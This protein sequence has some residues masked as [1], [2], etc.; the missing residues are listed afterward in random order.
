MP[1]FD[2]LTACT[3]PNCDG[4]SGLAGR[5]GA[6]ADGPS[7]SA[8]RRVA[9]RPPRALEL[10]ALRIEHDHPMI[11]VAVGDEQ[12][13]GRRMHEHV[14]R[15]MDVGRVRVTRA[16]PAGADLH[17]ELSGVRE[18]QDHVVGAAARR[19][20]R[21]S[22]VAADPDESLGIDRD[23]VLA[24][25]P[26]VAAPRH[27]PSCSSSLPAVS[28]SRTGG[29]ALRALLGRNR[30][31]PMQHP[32]VVA[33]IDG[34]GRDF[35]EHPVVGNRRP[36]RIELEGRLLQRAGLPAR[37]QP[38]PARGQSPAASRSA[39]ARK[40]ESAGH[41]GHV[42]APSEA[43]SIRG[44]LPGFAGTGPAARPTAGDRTG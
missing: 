42:Q 41:R 17:H 18:L 9:K 21:P 4:P 44:I 32:D 10:S 40:E 1:S 38:L 28:N 12:L 15:L 31:R 30:A 2:T 22:A 14:G 29:A 33:R 6:G 20:L 26:V 8:A 27:R 43:T 35:A 5:R 13:I 24:L 34:D 11:A 25:G 36:L 19:R 7:A 16:L 23:A 3:R 39:R 37:R